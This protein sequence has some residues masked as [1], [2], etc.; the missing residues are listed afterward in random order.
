MCKV[1]GVLWQHQQAS[2]QGVPHVLVPRHVG[3]DTVLN[4]LRREMKPVRGKRKECREEA[5]AAAAA[6]V[7]TF[8]FLPPSE[9]LDERSLA[10]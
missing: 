6:V 1:S 7:P 5:A 9:P 3:E 2:W 4:D 10:A 8:I